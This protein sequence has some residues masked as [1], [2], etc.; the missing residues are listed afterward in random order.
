MKLMK[1][2]V[3]LVTI[4]LTQTS[5]SP[6]PPLLPSSELSLTPS[7][8]NIHQDT[9]LVRAVRLYE[10]T[11]SMVGN[12][13]WTMDSNKFAV[14]SPYASPES[15]VEMYNATTYELL[16]NVPV[17]RG[18]SAMVF[19]PDEKSIYAGL[20]FPIGYQQ[21]DAA[22]GKLLSQGPEAF[23][24]VDENCHEKQA[25]DV[26]L[27][28]DGKTLFFL[29]SD[30]SNKNMSFSEI[31]A[32]DI[33]SFQCKK[34]LMRAEGHARTLAINPTGD[35]LA[36]SV[37]EGISDYRTDKP[38]DKGYTIVWDVKEDA[39]KC[40]IPGTNGV[41]VPRS[42]N[43]IVFESELGDNNK[44]SNRL[45]LWNAQNCEFVREIAT[46]ALPYYYLSPLSIT[47]DGNFLAV[48]QRD[49]K[50]VDLTT[51][52]TVATI[53]DPSPQAPHFDGMYDI[54]SFSPDGKLLLF[55]TPVNTE[56]SLV[57]LW[58]IES[59]KR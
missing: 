4:F 25:L 3:I 27:N 56:E 43:L 53:N 12:V 40:T 17:A 23:K 34:T 15:R 21:L 39:L 13:K 58:R 11:V 41:F 30:D 37:S 38:T 14:A 45:I 10:W 9:S 16:W 55:S 47:P 33:D 59:D 6:Q 26:V 2:S 28:G 50:I 54:L 31:Q 35:I 36:I 19:N 20:S 42:N 48:G 5:C 52:A 18:S 32:W 1:F 46:M 51:G 44:W 22:N 49:I 29:V 57:T 24:S 7:P 8:T